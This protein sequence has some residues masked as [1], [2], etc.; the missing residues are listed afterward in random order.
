VFRTNKKGKSYDIYKF[1]GK[2][3]IKQETSEKYAPD[4]ASFRANY[5]M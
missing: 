4:P 3:P 1:A 5:P 2:L